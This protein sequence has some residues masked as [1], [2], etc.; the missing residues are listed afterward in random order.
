M[1]AVVAVLTYSLL[2]LPSF[3]TFIARRLAGYLKSSYGLNISIEKVKIQFVKTVELEG[4]YVEDLKGDTLLYSKSIALNLSGY[5]LDDNSFSLAHFELNDTRFRME[6]E[7]PDSSSNLVKVLDLFDSNDTTVSDGPAFKLTAASVEINNLHFTM[8]DLYDTTHEYGMDYEDMDIRSFYFHAEDLSL[9]DDSISADISLIKAKEKCGFVLSHFEGQAIASP[10]LVEVQDLKM[11]TPNS[12]VKGDLKLISKRWGD[13]LDFVHKVKMDVNLN[14]CK[15][16]TGDIATYAPELKDW[17][18]TVF[19]SGKAKG[20]VDNLKCKGIDLNFLT[21][22]E[23][24][25]NFDISGLPEFESSFITIKAEK[26]RTNAEDVQSIC[27]FA[28]DTGIVIP[29]ELYNAGD[30]YFAGSFT[31]FPNEFTSY[32][33]FTSDAGV[34]KTDLTLQEK[35]SA[36]FYKG[37]LVTENLDL[38]MITEL[39]DIGTL[40]SS[41]NIEGSGFTVEELEAKIDGTFDSF[42]Y[43]GYEYADIFLDGDFEQKRFVGVLTC[44]DPNANFDFNG[45]IDFNQPKPLLDFDVQVYALNLS[46]LNLMADSLDAELSGTVKINAAGFDIATITGT[47]LI[48]NLSYCQ[49]KN[50][51]YFPEARLIAKDSPRE[52]QLLSPMADLSVKGIFIPEELPQSFIDVVAEA[53]PA[54]N[55]SKPKVVKKKNL[56][57]QDFTFSATIKDISLLKEFIS[58][59]LKIK[60]GT[61]INGFYNNTTNV[62]EIGLQSDFIRFADY[63]GYDV[64]VAARKVNDVL[65]ADVSIGSVQLSDSM[66]FNNVDLLA[67]AINDNLQFSLAW[68]NNER[69]RGKLEGV[70]QILGTGKF[71]IDLLPAELLLDGVVWNTTATSNIFYDSTRLNIR[72]FHFVSGNQEISAEGKLSHLN[73]DKLN[74]IIKNFDLHT[75]N[76][77]YPISYDIEGKVNGRGYLSNPYKS[78]NFQAN[79]T[80]NDVKF[81]KE[82]VGDIVFDANWARADSA[83]NIS[84]YL[85]K[86]NIKTFN[87]VGTYRPFVKKN[88]LD[89]K[90]SLNNFNLIAINALGIEQITGFAGFVSGGINISGASEEPQLKGQLV[91]RDAQIHIDYLNTTYHLNDKVQV[92][93]DWIG[94]NRI[95]VFDEKG[96]KA[97]AT[98]T[99]NHKNYGEWD[100]DISVDMKD[101]LCI[102]TDVTMNDMFYGVAYATGD[103]NISGYDDNLDI[104]VKATTRKGTSIA[105]P[106]GGAEEVAS[107]ELVRFVNAKEPIQIEEESGLTGIRLNL[108]IEATED[109]KIQL[110]FD[111]KIGDIITGYGSGNI[112]LAI[113][114]AGDFKMYGTY[115]IYKGD[116]LFTLKNVVNK[117]FSINAGST[118]TWFGNPYEAYLDITAVYKAMA[119]L[120]DIMLVNDERY[121]RREA[122]NCIMKMTGK[123]MEPKIRFDIKVPNADDFVRNQIA[124]VTSDENELNKQ[125]LSLLV[126]NRFTPLQNGVREGSGGSA[127]SSNS[128]ELLSN[129]LSN[130]LNGNNER[131]TV[132]VNFRS[133]D[134]TSTGSATVLVGTKLFNDRVNVYTNVGYGSS[135]IGQTATNQNAN[136]IVGDIVAEYNLTKDGRIKVKAFNQTSDNIYSNSS[137]S[138]YIQGAGISY[139]EQFD[140]FRELRQNVLSLFTRR[141]KLQINEE[142]PPPEISVP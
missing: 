65:S 42:F 63:S 103:V 141:K 108:D 123:L 130:W 5:D 84:A 48:Q 98:G 45:D 18:K 81:N 58:D 43:K 50:A 2:Y 4:V 22:T 61:T 76:A 119:S 112:K 36:Y 97:I 60:S 71:N 99:A 17:K 53:I 124:A 75:I 31:G 93:P 54:I 46:E 14:D 9:I 104:E 23:F 12:N 116:Y 15:I 91:L 55:L 110:I 125:F 127:V 29:Q 92:N 96:N 134:N 25:G 28:V 67:K 62:F 138:P 68:S 21:G 107:Q 122:V 85:T 83:I 100:Y 70:G 51:Y 115:S 121:K 72:G 132:G 113:S 89:L 128:L 74:F 64:N 1:L 131:F 87:L 6:T 117:K 102:N 78:L 126:A 41:I 3:Q 47:A 19:I 56:P 26:I 32:G 11:V 94:F 49:G 120:Y 142:L 135:T 95:V 33:I 57:R 133:G 20:R 40:T 37:R 24:A 77:F 88:E 35:D 111:E 86:Q 38:G 44:N 69:N 106:L 101:F 39:P 82:L 66:Y 13:W 140:T 73:S 114:P 10:S 79:M 137:L 34:L 27:D 109:A 7:H 16:Y 30:L 136:N 129:Q 90:L 105:I 8:K 52:L 59:T 139:S 118:I 80:V